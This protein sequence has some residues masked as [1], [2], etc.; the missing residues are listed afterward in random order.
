MNRFFYFFPFLIF[1]FWLGCSDDPN[2]VGIGMLPP[3]DGLALHS[4]D[5]TAIT[6]TTY[7]QRITG[8]STRLL[9]GKTGTIQTRS[10][11]QF[12]GTPTGLSG[13][14]VDTAWLRFPVTYRFQDSSG[15]F[16]LEF[17]KVL[18]PW[19]KDSLRWDSTNSSSLVSS[20][21]DTI[22]QKYVSPTD[23]VIEIPVNSFI[24]SWF[25]DSL[26]SPYGMMISAAANCNLVL[27]CPT[28]YTTSDLRPELYIVYHTGTDTTHLSYRPF[29]QTFFA[30][31]PQPTTSDSVFFVQAGVSYRSKLNFDVTSIPSRAS[32]TKATLELTLNPST[33]LTLRN[34]YSSNSIVAHIAHNTDTLSSLSAFGTF[35]NDT[36]YTLS[37]DVKS[38]LQQIVSKR[39]DY[40]FVLRS[41]GDYIALDR[42]AF[43]GVTASDPNKR[44]RLNITYTILP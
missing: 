7:I 42:Y 9:F 6:T 40:G 29:Q 30:D 37:L 12:A 21:V 20:V 38:L 16:S 28:T 10:F 31:A 41:T 17:R 11:L 5:T 36:T 4:F 18:R 3:Q 33:A 19:V 43:Y 22:F 25:A 35:A 14:V 34:S 15:M 26:A 13:F 39:P 23:S 24:R 32:V 1:I 2:E 44:P 8:V 27:G